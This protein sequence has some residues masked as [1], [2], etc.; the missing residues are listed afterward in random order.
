MDK[1]DFKL[2]KQAMAMLEELSEL[3]PS[4]I[5]WINDMAMGIAT[6]LK[7]ITDR[8]EN[9]PKEPIK[10]CEVIHLGA[11]LFTP[12]R[13]LKEEINN[14][15]NLEYY[16]RDLDEIV[17]R[18]SVLVERNYIVLKNPKVRRHMRDITNAIILNL[19]AGPILN[20]LFKKLEEF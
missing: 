3:P 11:E 10:G 14:G 16:L 15:L 12:I 2:S 19:E 13:T 9:P 7:E 4:E 8:I 1:T 17:E 5:D 18:L 6:T 20:S